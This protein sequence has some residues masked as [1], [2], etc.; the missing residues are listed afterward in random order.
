[1]HY[2]HEQNAYTN[3]EGSKQ[4]AVTILMALPYLGGVAT[5]TIACLTTVW[6][7]GRERR[8]PILLLTAAVLPLLFFASLAAVGI[9]M[10]IRYVFV[11]L[12]AWL[13]LASVGLDR[14]YRVLHARVGLW[15]ALTPLIILLAVSLFNCYAYYGGGAGFRS[16][17][18]DA[19]A[20]VQ[21]HRKPSD[22]VAADYI[23]EK[24][25]R[26]YLQTDDI[27]LVPADLPPSALEAID[28]PTWMV[29][30]GHAPTAGERYT[31]LHD[32]A[33][34]KAYFANQILQPYSSVHV[35][36]YDPAIH[37]TRQH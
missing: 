15:P 14:L 7:F 12:F 8:L 31:W 9:D 23:P 28:R 25:G 2:L 32:L 3:F 5:T 19:F 1:M 4:P 27:T 22:A 11:S 37:H 16:R 21:A 18:A 30:R 29:L 6:L 33:D 17:W 10:H 20:Y 34:F 36:Y 24:I 35:Y 13:A 26:Y